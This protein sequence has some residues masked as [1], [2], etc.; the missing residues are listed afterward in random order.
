MRF[1]RLITTLTIASALTACVGSQTV[2]QHP[3][4]KQVV[5]CDGSATSLA[6]GGLIGQ[7]IT[8]S[9]CVEQHKQLGFVPASD[10]HLKEQMQPMT[11]F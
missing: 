2:M 8:H 4:T 5:T 9:N 6:A 3:D 10:G 11:A 7:S 1:I